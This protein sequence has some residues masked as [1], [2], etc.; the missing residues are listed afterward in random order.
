MAPSHPQPAISFRP[1]DSNWGPIPLPVQA[2]NP[3][4]VLWLDTIDPLFVGQGSLSRVAWATNDHDVAPAVF[5]S[6]AECNHVVRLLF[7]ILERR[8][9]IGAEDPS[10]SLWLA[11][12]T[13]S[14]DIRLPVFNNGKAVGFLALFT[15][16]VWGNGLALLVWN[17]GN[18]DLDQC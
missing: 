15:E 7:R 14:S 12:V 4:A 8:I 5:A 18:S 6:V 3:R 16:G 17:A 13:L 10:P 1:E 2:L 9:A 11:A